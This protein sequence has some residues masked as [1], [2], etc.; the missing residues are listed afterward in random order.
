MHGAS[1]SLPASAIVTL[2]LQPSGKHSQLLYGER[3]D[4]MLLL[5]LLLLLPVHLLV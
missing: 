4:I 1:T 3:G 2:N 5:L